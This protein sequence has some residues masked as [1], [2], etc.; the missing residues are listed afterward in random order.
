[1]RCG[2]GS[3]K[4]SGPP[5]SQRRA[6]IWRM[7]HHESFVSVLEVGTQLGELIFV[8]GSVHELFRYALIRTPLNRFRDGVQCPK[9]VRFS[10]V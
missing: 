9:Q 4:I 8:L 7:T 2:C 3:E 10:S 1:V 5:P 6:F